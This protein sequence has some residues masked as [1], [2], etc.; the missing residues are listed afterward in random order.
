MKDYDEAYK[1]INRR[2]RRRKTKKKNKTKNRSQNTIDK[3]EKRK[4]KNLEQLTFSR[5]YK[6]PKE[7]KVCRLPKKKCAERVKGS[8]L[9]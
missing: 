1:Q 6:K 9:F 5:H 8:N 3:A 2:P 4:N 7:K